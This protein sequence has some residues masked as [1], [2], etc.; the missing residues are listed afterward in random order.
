MTQKLAKTP[1]A[2]IGSGNI[3]TDLMIKIL[4]QAQHL[5]MAVMVGTALQAG[6]VLGTL[7]MGPVIDRIGFFKVLI[8]CFV[9]AAGTLAMIGQ[10][11]IAL[12]LLFIVTIITGF[13]IIGGQPAVNA[14]AATYYPTTLR[15]TGV[16]WSLGIGRFGSIVG[17]VLG[18]ALIQFEWSNSAIFHAM[19]VPTL[20]SAVMLVFFARETRGVAAV[21]P[22]KE[23]D[24]LSH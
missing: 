2:I 12:P 22:S 13:C 9:I 6:G 21:R 14:L 11:G 18:G 15:S 16:G 5:E 10:P 19:A 8:P 4:R 3:G 7:L 24:L 23:A 17:P 1:V 20:I